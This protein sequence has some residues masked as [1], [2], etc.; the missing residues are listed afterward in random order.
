MTPRFCT[1]PTAESDSRMISTILLMKPKRRTPWTRP[2]PKMMKKPRLRALLALRCSMKQALTTH[3]RRQ[4]KILRIGHITIFMD[5]FAR[6]AS[7]CWNSVASA[8]LGRSHSVAWPATL[9]LPRRKPNLQQR[10]H[11]HASIVN[12]DVRTRCLTLIPVMTRNDQ[13]MRKRMQRRS[14]SPSS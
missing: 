3:P 11:T 5:L 8:F 9:R 13:T 6:A 7:D 14:W 12:A 4:S 10:T 1:V 2:R